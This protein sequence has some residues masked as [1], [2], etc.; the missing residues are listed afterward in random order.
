MNIY[1][2]LFRRPKLDENYSKNLVLKKKC[3]MQNK[4]KNSLTKNIQK[5]DKQ[6]K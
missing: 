6:N 4:I 5:K 2:M 1:L 3:K